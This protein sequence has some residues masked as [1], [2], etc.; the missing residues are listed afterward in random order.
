M[1]VKKMSIDNLYF[2]HYLKKMKNKNKNFTLTQI[3]AIQP[4]KNTFFNQIH[5]KN[6]SFNF[7]GD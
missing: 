6:A 4:N 2:I 5:L 7:C 1:H 3:N